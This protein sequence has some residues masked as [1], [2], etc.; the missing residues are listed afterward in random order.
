M[1]SSFV[2]PETVHYPRGHGTTGHSALVAKRPSLAAPRQGV[3]G[4]KQP[5]RRGSAAAPGSAPVSCIIKL[6]LSLRKLTTP[7]NRSPHQ[8][9]GTSC[10]GSRWGRGRVACHSMPGLL[11][12]LRTGQVPPRLA[13]RFPADASP[14]PDRLSEAAGTTHH[15]RAGTGLHRLSPTPWQHSFQDALDKAH[16]RYS[17]LDLTDTL[18]SPPPNREL[19]C[20][21]RRSRHG[22]PL[23]FGRGLSAPTQV[24]PTAPAAQLLVRPP[25]PRRSTEAGHRL[26]G[27]VR[28]GQ[29]PL[30]R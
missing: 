10:F 1:A 3:E 23:P 11:A 7:A 5:L 4:Q 13:G 21:L 18:K 25:S 16:R 14:I 24:R 9:S 12:T 20:K 26:A 27:N 19:S 15:P 8:L 28:R 2:E 6:A 22:S 17:P 30:T 29:E